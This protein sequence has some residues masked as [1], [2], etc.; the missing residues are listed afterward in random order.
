MEESDS[1]SLL[2]RIS[3][4]LF[5]FS[6]TIACFAWFIWSAIE[7][8]RSVYD[9]LPVIIFDK[10]SMYALGAGIT[11]I[12]IT[13]TGVYQGFM[14]LELSKRQETLVKYAM[15]SGVIVMFVFPQIVHYSVS[16]IIKERSYYSCEN[17]SY[18]WLLYKKIVYTKNIV[19]CNDFTREKEITKNI[20][21]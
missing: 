15:I 11:S 14:R 18:Q 4:F 1:P 9:K 17:M 12:V 16:K 2:A 3:G 10:G 5:F 13:L 7:L 6:I 21:P 20:E 19:T 8:F